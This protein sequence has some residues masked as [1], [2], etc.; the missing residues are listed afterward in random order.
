MYVPFLIWLLWI[1]NRLLID[2]RIAPRSGLASKNFIDVGA[3]VIDADVYIS[4]TSFYH[5]ERE[6]NQGNIVPWS[7]QGSPL[8]PWRRRLCRQG[9]RSHRAVDSREGMLSL[10]SI[11]L[12]TGLGTNSFRS[13]L[14]KSSRSMNSMKPL[15][16]LAGSEARVFASLRLFSLFFVL[17]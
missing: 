12:V 1:V 15:E 10:P 7:S 9:G 17:V 14:R 11:C 13:S 3:G 5:A 4:S 8:Q 2:G 16:V 6:I